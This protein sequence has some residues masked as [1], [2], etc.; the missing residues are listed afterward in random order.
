MNRFNARRSSLGGTAVGQA[1]V[2]RESACVRA[3]AVG[4]DVAARMGV[5]VAYNVGVG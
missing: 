2:M 1:S 5:V 4:C 3:T